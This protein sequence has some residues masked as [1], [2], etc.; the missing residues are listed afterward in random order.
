[1][2]LAYH[3]VLKLFKKVNLAHY[4]LLKSEK[5]GFFNFV[6]KGSNF[7]RLKRS[8]TVSL[9]PTTKSETNNKTPAGRDATNIEVRN[10]VVYLNNRT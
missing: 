6:L 7:F 5:I 3:D 8:D 4:L 2:F 1:M 10:F 9:N